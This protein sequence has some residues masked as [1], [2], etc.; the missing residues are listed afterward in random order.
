V[1]RRLASL[2]QASHEVGVQGVAQLD[3]TRTSALVP[4]KHHLHRMPRLCNSLAAVGPEQLCL[5]LL[6]CR[7]IGDMYS[8]IPGVST[9]AV[10]GAARLLH[11]MALPA[12]EPLSELAAVAA[13]ASGSGNSNSNSNSA[14]LPQQHIAA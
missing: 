13:A 11:C 9:S 2:V 14:L 1:Q 3:T 10:P 7:A 5:P 6:V 8:G 12:M 4:M